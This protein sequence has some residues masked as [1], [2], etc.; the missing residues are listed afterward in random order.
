[1]L[2][3][4]HSSC[5]MSK[6]YKQM[7]IW[8]QHS[9]KQL[10]DTNIDLGVTLKVGIKG[11]KATPERRRNEEDSVKLK[12]RNIQKSKV[13]FFFLK[14]ELCDMKIIVKSITI[15]STISKGYIF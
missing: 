2:D 1:M 13:V 3:Q 11:V 4:R 9:G 6:R 14:G 15:R 5:D 7:N 8:V 10:S 12:R